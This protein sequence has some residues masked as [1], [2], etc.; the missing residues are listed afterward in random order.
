MISKCKHK[1][2][3]FTPALRFQLLLL[4]KLSFNAVASLTNV[5]RAVDYMQIA[6]KAS[7]DNEDIYTWGKKSAYDV[8]IVA[9]W[10]HSSGV[11]ADIK[12]AYSRRMAMA[13]S[14]DYCYFL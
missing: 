10:H 3:I 1:Q 13:F 7:S 11:P 5:I 4:H 14:Y 2:L 9:R 6:T 8:N 12:S